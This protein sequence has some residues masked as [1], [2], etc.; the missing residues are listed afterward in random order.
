MYVFSSSGKWDP[1]LWLQATLLSRRRSTPVDLDVV[2]EMEGPEV[3]RKCLEGGPAQRVKEEEA[4][5]IIL[6]PQRRSFSTGCHLTAA[7]KRSDSPDVNKE[8]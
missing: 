5:G 7:N 6:S 2:G 3:K 4:E 8:K 1:I